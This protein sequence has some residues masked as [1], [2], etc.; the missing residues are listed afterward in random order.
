[1]KHRMF[2]Q[3]YVGGL[4][5]GRNPRETGANTRSTVGADFLFGTST[6][7]GTQNL[8]VGGFFLN[9]TKMSSWI[10]TTAYC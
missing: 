9:T 4:F 6:F 3:S 10:L 8:S 7:L 1:V 2:R 5:T